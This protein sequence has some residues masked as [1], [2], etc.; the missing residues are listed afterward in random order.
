MKRFGALLIATVLVTGLAACGDDTADDSGGDDTALDDTSETSEAGRYG[1]TTEPVASDEGAT[2]LVTAGTQYGEIMIDAGT[3]LTVYVFT[4]DTDTT[5]TCVDACEGAWPPLT[6]PA[7]AGDGVDADLIGT[8]TRPDGSEQA[9][10][11]GHPL[12]TYAGDEAAGDTNGQGF[13]DKWFVVDA[14]GNAVR[15]AMGG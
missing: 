3:S 12:Y 9:T 5:S 14:G 4:D 6:A 13:G 8:T 15:S 11:N 1:D 2:N 7:T 10:Y